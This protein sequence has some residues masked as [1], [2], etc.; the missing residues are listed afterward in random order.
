MFEDLVRKAQGN[1]TAPKGS[2]AI[3]PGGQFEVASVMKGKERLSSKQ[4]TDLI[5]CSSGKVSVLLNIMCSLGIVK[6]NKVANKTTKSYLF[7]L[8][9]ENFALKGA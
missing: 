8:S 3:L 2:F 4:I 7:S 6:K 5:G 1:F 9:V